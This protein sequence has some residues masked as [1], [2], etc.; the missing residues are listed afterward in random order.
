MFPIESTEGMIKAFKNIIFVLDYVQKN[1]CSEDT[2][3]KIIENDICPMTREI[4][5]KYDFFIAG[6]IMVVCSTVDDF[7]NEDELMD[8]VYETI[9]KFICL[10]EEAR[11]L[12]DSDL[13]ENNPV[14]D[15]EDIQGIDVSR[16]ESGVVV[17]NY[18][19]MCEILEEDICEGN[20]KKAQLKE[21][22]RYFAWEKK[23]Q[24]FIIL[25]I[26]DEPL[27][28]DD[29]RQNKNIYVQ[30]IQ[31]ILMKI[32]SK[33]RNTKEPFYITTNQMWKLLGMINDNYK[34]GVSQ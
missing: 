18:K 29:G 16:L 19:E 2:I 26:Y 25:D 23:G 24:K 15:K 1:G 10:L 17:K 11:K 21:W 13:K 33:Q 32:L 6:T 7:S 27:P 5:D 22:T 31:V 4:K 9:G 30:Y 8:L 3:D 28:K 14:N 12:F 20:S 34:N